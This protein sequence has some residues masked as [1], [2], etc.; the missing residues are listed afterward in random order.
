MELAPVTAGD[1]SPAAK[2]SMVAH[3]ARPSVAALRKSNALARAS[4][5]RNSV[6]SLQP[7]SLVVI[8][9]T[10]ERRGLEMW[11]RR[12][13]KELALASALLFVAVVWLFFYVVFL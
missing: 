13:A 11:S 4:L 7:R 8:L 10:G 1:D 9:Q 2:S 5:L 12:N 6:G 3:L